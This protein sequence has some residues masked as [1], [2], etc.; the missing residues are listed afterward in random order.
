MSIV[1][2]MSDK[3]TKRSEKDFASEADARSASNKMASE[4]ISRGY[5][6]SPTHGQKPASTGPAARKPASGA[7]EPDAVRPAGVFDDVEAPAG[8]ASP[9][10]QR[11]SPAPGATSSTDSSQQK[12]K[13]K[14]GKKKKKTQSSDALDKRVLAGVAAVGIALIGVIAFVVYDA[15]IKPPTIVGVWRGGLVEHEI[16][17]S[18]TVTEYDL[19]LDDQKRAALS[20]QV[21]GFAKT[22]LVGTYTVKGNRLKL[23]VKDDDGDS[24]DREYKIVL[25]R[26]SLELYDIE[27]GKMLVQL[28][29]FRETPVVRAQAPRRSKPV[30]PVAAEGETVDEPNE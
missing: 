27:S 16:S 30:E 12:K 29:R 17:R 22:S 7:R 15:F 18:L 10:L 13:K 9:V 6:E 26:V 3:S 25:D 23:T 24:S 19:V 2:T 1:Q 8:T 4:L 14:G 5:T 11:L 28:L 21:P 20:I